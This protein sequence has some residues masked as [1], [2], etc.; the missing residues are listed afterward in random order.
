M[1]TIICLTAELYCSYP[2]SD[3]ALASQF[4]TPCA[5]QMQAAVAQEPP[6]QLLQII[7][8][9]TGTPARWQNQSSGDGRRAPAAWIGGRWAFGTVLA[10][11][12]GEDV[13]GP[14]RTLGKVV[15]AANA[16]CQFS[17]SSQDSQDRGTYASH[18][19]YCHGGLTLP[20]RWASREWAQLHGPSWW[21]FFPPQFFP[22]FQQKSLFPQTPS[23]FPHLGN[24][25]T[26]KNPNLS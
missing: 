4:W 2:I 8:P 16:P 12:S 20:C 6:K 22:S 17:K 1:H 14:G 7:N 19:L 5:A 26:D 21:C 18:G 11:F 24:Y 15:K 13:A 9:V 25:C 3:V 23:H 10:L